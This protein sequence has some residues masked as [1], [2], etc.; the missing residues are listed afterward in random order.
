M[1]KNIIVYFVSEKGFMN[2]FFMKLFM[3]GFQNDGLIIEDIGTGNAYNMPIYLLGEI[4]EHID[5]AVVVSVYF[6]EKGQPVPMVFFSKDEINALIQR[7][8]KAGENENSFEIL[9]E[10]HRKIRE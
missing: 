7:L 8:D 6:D 10:V 3:E 4:E 2:R 9:K 1:E 5:K